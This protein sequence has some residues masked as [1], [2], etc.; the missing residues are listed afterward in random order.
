VS[1][2]P[3]QNMAVHN[4]TLIYL[5]PLVFRAILSLVVLIPLT[6]F[7]LDA[8]DFG[9]FALI[10]VL[11]LPIQALGSSSSRWVIGGNTFKGMTEDN[12]RELIFNLLLFEFLVRSLIVL[13]Y[14]LM[15][16]QILAL[17]FGEVSDLY[18]SFFHLALLASLLGSIWPTVS[19]LMIVQKKAIVY[20]IFLV[21]QLCING[22]VSAIGLWHL[23]WGVEALFIALVSA[24][25]VS[26]VFELWFI[27]DQVR[28]KPSMTSVRNITGYFLRS[29]PGGTIE[30]TNGLFER[31]LISQHVSL[32][33][34]GIYSHSQQYLGIMK[35]AT[36]AFSNVLTPRTLQVYSEEADA[37][38]LSALLYF[39][40]A[41]LCV[42]GIGMVFFADEFIA[43]L[44]HGK[45]TDAAPLLILWVFFTLS[46]SF[47]IPYAQ[48]LIA[49]KRTNLLMYTQVIPSLVGIVTLWPAIVTYGY[50]G[51]AVTML[52]VSLV[53]QF[54]RRWAALH[55]G[56]VA[57]NDK[58]F[59]A[60]LAILIII[61]ALDWFLKPTFSN[62]I[63]FFLSASFIY[64]WIIG[65]WSRIKN[66]IAGHANKDSSSVS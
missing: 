23:G 28:P 56:M 39:W 42:L 16:Q 49:F 26:L 14:F 11:V 35:S 66:Y 13:V 64:L 4:E 24:N 59:L 21:V 40:F 10:T 45:F 41:F 9:L 43:M 51:A 38:E 29:I 58:M 30:I 46:S 3:S 34:L 55:S 18:L 17:A 31:I 1:K 20:A 48:Y 7:F 62:E 61:W 15:G 32:A 12:Y 6:T 36:Q 37:R 52:S 53:T 22:L 47:G 54:S 2:K 60:S 63:L 19:Y 25:L 44:T 33:G 65:I 5:F 57:I 8:E 27:K 50:Y